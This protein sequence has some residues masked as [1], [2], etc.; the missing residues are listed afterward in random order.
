MS[1]ASGAAAAFFFGAAALAFF[2]GLASAAADGRF[3]GAAALP[4]AALPLA[5]ACSRTHFSAS[6]A[7]SSP[8]WAH[9]ARAMGE[10]GIWRSSEP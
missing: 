10:S 7:G 6:P 2:A 9:Q 1:S 8:R 3:R 4:G 5:R